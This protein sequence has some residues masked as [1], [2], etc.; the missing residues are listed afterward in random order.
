MALQRLNIEQARAK[1]AWNYAN[2]ER[3]SGRNYEG[4]VKKVPMYILTNGFANF[5]AFAQKSEWQQIRE[6]IEH[7]FRTADD[8]QDIIKHK[9]QGN[10]RSFMEIV[11]TDL[12]PDELRM[13]TFE[14]LQLFSWLRRF[15]K[16]EV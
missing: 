15:V 12:T 7:Y 8:V 5:L 11:A 16:E 4:N 10:N 1:A 9:F 13:V 2:R 14:T 6:D 3:K